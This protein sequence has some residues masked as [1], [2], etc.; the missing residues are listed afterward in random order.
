M[1]ADLWQDLRFA[2]RS[3]RIRPAFSAMVVL[4][5]GLG[6]A[7]NVAIFSLVNAALLR[8]LPVRAPDELVLFTPGWVLGRQLGP[9]PNG[10]EG[11]AV[12]FSYPLYEQLR[13]QTAGLTMAAQD[14]NAERALIRAQDA[15]SDDAGV[16]ATGRCVSANFFDVLGVPAYRGRTFQPDDDR[17]QGASPVIVLSHLFWARQFESDPALIGKTL[18][19]NGSAYTVIGVTP[20]GFRGATVGTPLDFWVPIGMANAF[21]RS[22]LDL[23]NREYYWL[24]PFGRLAPGATLESAQSSADA[25]LKR[26][27]AVQRRDRA[28]R[29]LSIELEPGATGFSTLR[30]H[31]ETPLL[32]LM[33]GVGLLLLIVCLNVS[34]LLI[35][36][37]MSRQH[38]MSIR[39]ALG[40][41]RTRLVRQL[42]TEGFVLAGLG[43]VLGV[44][45]T[46]WVSEGL[47]ALA[48]TGPG[49]FQFRLE[50]GMDRRVLLFTAGVALGIAVLLGLVP[51]WHALRSDLQQAMRA[52]AQ[53]VTSSGS[54]R[55]VSRVLLVS[56]VAFSLVLLMAAGLLA[57][58]LG[59]LREVPLGLDEEHVLMAALDVRSSGADDD[60]ARFLYEDI[61]RR[62]A[63]LPGV[64]AASVS[65]PPVLGGRMGW[66]VNF[67]GTDMPM[68]GF[69]WY[70]VTPGYFDALGMRLLRGRGFSSSDS[71]DAPRV[72]VVNETMARD[73][74]GGRDALGQRIRLDQEHDVEIVG[75]VSDART[76]GLRQQMEPLFYLPVAQ[77]HGVPA[78]I[79]PT[80]LEV[81][82]TGDPARLTELVR[83]TIAEAQSGLSPVDVRTLSEQVDRSIVVER[84]L[85]VLAAA[86]G[87]GALFL[88]AIGLYG[89]ISQWAT[90]RTREIGVRAALGATPGAVQWLVLRQALWLVLIGLGF[91]VPAAVGVSHLLKSLLFE[92]EPLHPG[93][94][95][96]AALALAAVATF[97]AYLPARRAARVDP[98]TALR[99][100]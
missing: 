59:K 15:A 29:D 36:R 1:I 18:N 49:P 96:G 47:I 34:H 19:V 76:Q 62:I 39:T 63:A 48:D 27:P 100:E 32:V 7:A 35:A 70:L 91:G 78:Q 56:Q 24:Q 85:A 87:L 13:D 86:F 21:T 82:G 38:E 73:E 9:A 72:A 67:P 20:P 99:Y 53:S 14:S 97:A 57:Q 37:A 83:R 81:R 93:A 10:V 98:M 41:T 52:T 50:M 26:L 88:V 40:A 74:F 28:G 11:R 75:V 60:R 3:L 17:A 51:A 42:L 45:L 23:E 79:E 64:L 5:L 30:R 95:L 4:T 68:K 69:G 2:L 12:L 92:V 43:A 65:H 71:S 25:S 22:G 66:G 31:F 84:L 80:S 77:P 94:M 54:R 46:R 58:S 33:C 61:P 8:P 90:Q 89:V 16:S 44:V 55:R 6:I